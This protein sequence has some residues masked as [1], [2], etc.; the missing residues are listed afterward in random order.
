MFSNLYLYTTVHERTS[1]IFLTSVLKSGSYF[2]T[3][4][5]SSFINAPLKSTINPD[6]C[7]IISISC[8]WQTLILSLNDVFYEKPHHLFGNKSGPPTPF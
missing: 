1:V 2:N 5:R 8:V 4:T 7:Y 6:T 3:L